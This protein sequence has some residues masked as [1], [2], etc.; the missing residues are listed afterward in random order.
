MRR[1]TNPPSCDVVQLQ[2]ADGT[3]LHDLIDCNSSGCPTS[4]KYKPRR[5]DED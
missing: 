3:L 2:L 5:D 1:H 4:S